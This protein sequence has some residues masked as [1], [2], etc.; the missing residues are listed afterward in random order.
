MKA[1]DSISSLQSTCVNFQFRDGVSRE[2]ETPHP[3]DLGFM[4]RIVIMYKNFHEQYPVCT[5]L[6]VSLVK[7]LPDTVL[8]LHYLLALTLFGA[9]LYW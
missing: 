5:F 4:S 1:L 8:E 2:E 6:K 7:I 9:R 3:R